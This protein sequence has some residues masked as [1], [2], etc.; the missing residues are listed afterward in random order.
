[1]ESSG[2]QE[3]LNSGPNKAAELLFVASCLVQGSACNRH[4]KTFVEL[5]CHLHIPDQGRET[6]LGNLLAD[7]RRLPGAHF[8]VKTDI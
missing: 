5:T 8:G 7:H 2:P 6:H 1:M 4:S 3:K